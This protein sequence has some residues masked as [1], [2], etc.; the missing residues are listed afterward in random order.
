[1][2]R[3]FIIGL[4]A[5]VA[6]GFVSPNAVGQIAKDQESTSKETAGQK[7]ADQ[8]AVNQNTSKK[9]QNPTIQETGKNRVEIIPE[10]EYEQEEDSEDNAIEQTLDILQLFEKGNTELEDRAS[11]MMDRML[12]HMLDYLAKKNTSEK[13]ATFQ[14]NYYDALIAKGFTSDQAFQLVL[15]LGNPLAGASNSGK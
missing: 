9:N 5:L 12:D 2:N 14:K 4:M 1:M 11:Q 3:F 8:N 10:E 15:N 6:I 7:A 13:L